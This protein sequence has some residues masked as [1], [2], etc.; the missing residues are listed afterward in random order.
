MSFS[1]YFGFRFGCS[2]GNIVKDWQWTGSKMGATRC[3]ETGAAASIYG[4]AGL[5]FHGAS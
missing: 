4:L 3:H 5:T 1:T 2:V